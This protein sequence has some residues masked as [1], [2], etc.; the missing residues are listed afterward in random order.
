MNCPLKAFCWVEQALLAT[1]NH[2]QTIA[3]DETKMYYYWIYAI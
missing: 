1:A 2:A 3:Q